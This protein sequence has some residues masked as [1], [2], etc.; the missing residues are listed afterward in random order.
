VVARLT[1]NQFSLWTDKIEMTEYAKELVEVLICSCCI[2]GRVEPLS[3]LEGL[4]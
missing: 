4:R 2:Q 3:Q 1:E